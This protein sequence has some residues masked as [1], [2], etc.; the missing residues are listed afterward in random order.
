MNNQDKKTY[1]VS[2]CLLGIHC[3]YDGL[4]AFNSQ[5]KNYLKNKS[6]LLTCPEKLGGLSTPRPPVQIIGRNSNKGY[7]G[8]SVWQKKARLLSE[9][10]KDLTLYF[11]AGCRLVDKLLKNTQVKKAFLKARSPSC[12]CGWVYNRNSSTGKTYLVKGDGVLAT[13]LKCRK[14]LIKS[15]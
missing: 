6:V 8:K 9:K 4:S 2:A 11:L 1:L 7:D 10:G 13:L 5:I 12:G 3:R 14:I 15:V